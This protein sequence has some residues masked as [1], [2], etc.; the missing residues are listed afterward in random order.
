M[1]ARDLS[2]ENT[3][4]SRAKRM[5]TEMQDDERKIKMTD[6]NRNGRQVQYLVLL[7]DKPQAFGI[8]RDKP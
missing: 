6:S 5:K 7:R 4:S 1:A 8:I 2:P 3:V